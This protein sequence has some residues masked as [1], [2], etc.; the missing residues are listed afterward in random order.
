VSIA[1]FFFG[2][3]SVTVAS[4]APITRYNTDGSPHQVTIRGAKVQRNSVIHKGQA[5]QL[6]VAEPG[7]YEYICGLH[8]QMK[9]KIEVK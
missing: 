9:G 7:S 4:N 1:N 5:A 8:P 2:P 3:E 6:S